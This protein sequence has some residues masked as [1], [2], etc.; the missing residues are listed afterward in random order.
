MDNNAV[1]R[2]TKRK[3]HFW[4]YCSDI[5]NTIINRITYFANKDYVKYSKFIYTAIY[6]ELVKNPKF[7]INKSFVVELL[8]RIGKGGS[9]YYNIITPYIP[10]SIT[11]KFYEK[12]MGYRKYSSITDPYTSPHIILAVN[13]I[14][15]LLGDSD[16]KMLEGL[17]IMDGD[18]Q[19]ARL[20]RHY[21]GTIMLNLY[22]KKKRIIRAA[23]MNIQLQKE[24]K[25]RLLHRI[26][27]LVYKHPFVWYDDTSIIESDF[28]NLEQVFPLLR[29]ENRDRYHDYE[30]Y[31]KALNRLPYEV[32][33]KQV[34]YNCK[35]DPY[36]IANY[37]YQAGEHVKDNDFYATM[38]SEFFVKLKYQH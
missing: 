38:N 33:L 29:P 37:I 1:P 19:S 26:N 10:H 15:M 32:R 3:Q 2:V 25:D 16:I 23:K 6:K 24:G 21:N 27:E 35:F 30:V 4:I 22:I 36:E 7:T 9:P 28:S 14:V 18:I 17:G 34:E 11:T 5:P 12:L 31:Q 8:I 20:I 13:R